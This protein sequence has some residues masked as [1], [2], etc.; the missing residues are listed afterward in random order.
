MYI[1]SIGEELPLQ[2]K[3]LRAALAETSDAQETPFQKCVSRTSLHLDVS[4]K[5]NFCK[6]Y[7]PTLARR[8]ELQ[9]DQICDNNID[10]P[11]DKK[12]L[13]ISKDNLLNC[14]STT[15][16]IGVKIS[17]EGI[18][19]GKDCPN[20]ENSYTPVKPHCDTLCKNAISQKMKTKPGNDAVESNPSSSNSKSSINHHTVNPVNVNNKVRGVI[21]C[22]KCKDIGHYARDCPGIR[23]YRCGKRGHYT[24][25]C[26]RKSRSIYS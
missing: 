14:K 19:Y 18:N 6:K 2:R 21:R 3:I 5:E 9:S 25:N 4:Y 11:I 20:D 23:C 7:E 15:E 16:L 24:Y 1:C 8:S 12:S 26:K 22:F 10:V 17:D 13:S